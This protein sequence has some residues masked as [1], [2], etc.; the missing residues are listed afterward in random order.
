MIHHYV[1]Q[2]PRRYQSRYSVRS[3]NAAIPF[4]SGRAAI[5]FI[6]S[7]SP[8]NLHTSSTV[9]Q[10]LSGSQADLY[11]TTSTTPTPPTPWVYRSVSVLHASMT[12]MRRRMMI[13]TFLGATT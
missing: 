9:P 12:M 8:A 5:S 11:A 7:A 13:I 3:A 10:Q 2:R 6:R 4:S 1:A